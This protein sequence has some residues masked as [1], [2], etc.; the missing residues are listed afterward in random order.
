MYTAISKE[1]CE[2]QSN[3]HIH[4]GTICRGLIAA[5][6]LWIFTLRLSGEI[7]LYL[8]LSVGTDAQWRCQAGKKRKRKGKC[9]FSKTRDNSDSLDSETQVL[10]SRQWPRRSIKSPGTRVN[11][12][13]GKRRSLAGWW[14]WRW[15]GSTLQPYT[16]PEGLIFAGW[17]V[18]MLCL[19]FLLAP[20]PF[21]FFTALSKIWILAMTHVCQWP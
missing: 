2:F 15:I 3:I 17:Q 11:I 10:E 21:F 7:Q 13:I 6:L 9:L 8:F 18:V 1:S 20:A 19:F 4:G 5:R 12:I 14:F 16:Q